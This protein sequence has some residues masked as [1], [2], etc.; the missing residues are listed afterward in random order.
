MATTTPLSICCIYLSHVLEFWL[1]TY[2]LSIINSIDSFMRSDRG[3]LKKNPSLPKC[4]YWVRV[5]GLSSCCQHIVWSTHEITWK[6]PILSTCSPHLHNQFVESIIITETQPSVVI[7][8]PTINQLYWPVKQMI[9]VFTRYLKSRFCCAMLLKH[10]KFKGISY[11][12]SS[13][14]V[15]YDTCK[16][17]CIHF[18]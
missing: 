9:F 11:A 5:S 18:G 3:K 14:C 1:Y 8:L 15:N 10:N 13:S 6:V 7:D 17:T 2:V 16:L 4:M 12:F